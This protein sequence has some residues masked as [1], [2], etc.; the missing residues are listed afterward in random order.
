MDKTIVS[1]YPNVSQ[2]LNIA[3]ETCKLELGR[4]QGLREDTR[5]SIGVNLTSGRVNSIEITQR[6]MKAPPL[7]SLLSKYKE[8]LTKKPSS[9]GAD[10]VRVG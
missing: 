10:S 7:D 1:T 2:I 9:V 3:R 4:V 6:A 8:Q 5:R